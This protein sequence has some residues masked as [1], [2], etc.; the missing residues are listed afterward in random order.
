MTFND[1]PKYG[2]TLGTSS[3]NNMIKECYANSIVEERK[4]LFKRTH[5]LLFVWGDNTADSKD[6]NVYN[7]SNFDTGLTFF[8][9]ADNLLL[10]CFSGFG[11]HMQEVYRL[12][13]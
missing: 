7:V 4:L 2:I 10:H 12:H 5:T 9:K 8:V 6:G 11:R 13:K 1:H 3:R